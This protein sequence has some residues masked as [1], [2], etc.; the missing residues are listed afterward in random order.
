VVVG[1]CSAESSLAQHLLGFDRMRFVHRSD[2]V[3]GQRA[4]PGG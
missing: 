3:A 2:E 4:D 1:D